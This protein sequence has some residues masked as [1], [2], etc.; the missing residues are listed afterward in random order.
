MKVLLTG[1]AGTGKSTITRALKERG[2]NAIDLHDVP[3]L[4]YWEDKITKKRVEYSPV[5]DREWFNGVNR[6]CD[7]EMLKEM[8]NQYDDV[9]MAGTAGD[10]QSEYFPLFDRIILLQSDPETLIHRMKTRVNKSGYGKTASE[11][12]DNIEWQKEF[13]PE[14]LSHGAIPVNTSGHIDDVVNKIMDLIK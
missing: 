2:I 13:D 7:I 14:V 3:S 8:L 6:F 12:E 5:N 4:C 9:V 11:Q 10:N 1:I